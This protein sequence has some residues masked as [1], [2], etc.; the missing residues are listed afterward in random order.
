MGG[1]A[2]VRAEARP[3]AGGAGRRRGGRRRWRFLFLLLLFSLLHFLSSSSPA[4]GRPGRR[5][6]CAHGPGSAPRPGRPAAPHTPPLLT[7]AFTGILFFS[8]ALV[9]SEFPPGPCVRG[10]FAWP[11]GDASRGTFPPWRQIASWVHRGSASR[12]SDPWSLSGVEC[13]SAPHTLWGLRAV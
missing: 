5:P 11:S 12:W 8:G 13:S 1:G 4:P 6:R 10:R 7:A 9:G 3:A 2:M